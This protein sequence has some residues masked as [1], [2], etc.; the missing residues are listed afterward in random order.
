MMGKNEMLSYDKKKELMVLLKNSV[1]L[2]DLMQKL[3]HM[4]SEEIYEEI[5]IIV[6]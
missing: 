2:K 3:Y 4:F 6:Y 1:H 5:L